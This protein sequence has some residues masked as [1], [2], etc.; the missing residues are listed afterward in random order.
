[1]LDLNIQTVFADLELGFNSTN[2]EDDQV[3]NDFAFVEADGKNMLVF[4]SGTENKAA[5]I[6]L[7][8]VNNPTY[9]TL[10]ES[11]ENSARSRRRQVEW[12]VGTPYVWVDGTQASKVYVINVEKKQ[13]VRTIEGIKTTKILGVQNFAKMQQAKEQQVAVD[14]AIKAAQA[15]IA[16]EKSSSSEDQMSS[17]SE[18]SGSEEGNVAA[19]AMDAATGAEY[20]DD[21]DIDA[22]GIIGL[23][24]GACALIVGTMNVFVMSSMKSQITSNKDD[25]ISLGSK[26]VA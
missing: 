5:I 18:S 22:I 24:V 25:L 16:A 17:K 8:D 6:D 15:A 26:D 2:N 12:A 9:V 4:V 11:K 21:N 3:F 7:A 20:K 13:K 23:I 1:M 19:A 14:A 10:S